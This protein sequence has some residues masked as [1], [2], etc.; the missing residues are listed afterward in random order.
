ML[1][2]YK[3]FHKSQN[4]LVSLGHVIKNFGNL[5]TIFGFYKVNIRVVGKIFRWYFSKRKIRF[6][7]NRSHVNI[8]Y[9]NNN[10]NM[11]K[12]SQGKYD[13]DLLTLGMVNINKL[14]YFIKYSRSL[15]VFTK[16]GVFINKHYNNKLG[17]ISSYV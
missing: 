2:N 9:F 5:R 4:V 14:H 16:R 10:F 11:F 6:I 13:S 3:I 8:L 1:N 7:L 17:K 12:L 15:N